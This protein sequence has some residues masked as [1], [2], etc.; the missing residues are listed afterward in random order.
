MQFDYDQRDGTYLV[1]S[2]DHLQGKQLVPHQLQMMLNNQIPQLLNVEL[3]I[4]NDSYQLQYDLT[5]KRR[6]FQML[7][8]CPPSIPLFYEMSYRLV[9][10]I[11]NSSM[12]MLNEEQYILHGDFIFGGR[13]VGDLYLCY[14]PLPTTYSVRIEDQLR[15][16]LIRMLA[17]ID[18][19]NGDCDGILK[20]IKII[21]E[22]N[23]LIPNLMNVLKDAWLKQAITPDKPTIHSQHS[24]SKENAPTNRSQHIW[25]GIKRIWNKQRELKSHSVKSVSIDR[26]PITGVTEMLVKKQETTHKE[27]Q[28]VISKNGVD[29]VIQFLD[30]RFIIGRNQSG[31]HYVDTT[32]GISRV[33]C[34]FMRNK[35]TLEIKDLGS[36]NG[37]YLNG[38]LLVPY[39]SYPFK[40]GDLLRIVT[41]EIR[42][43][44]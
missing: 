36:L 44:T 10:T 24:I 37:S 7:Q 23:Y 38:V 19:L 26:K 33:H 25:G 40:Y 11:A 30:D 8:T 2:L 32:E 4:K 42:I 1:I 6:L 29:E 15:L 39:K 18:G 34:E 31:V 9:Q 28:V 16:I 14:L 20:V 5:S 41:T 43:V 17:T 12:Y 13:D 22:E 35:D 3:E 27:L 21:Q